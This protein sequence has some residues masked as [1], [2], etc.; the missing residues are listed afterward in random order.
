VSERVLEWRWDE[1]SSGI[2]TV[3]TQGR[4]WFYLMTIEQMLEAQE[5]LW[6]E[7]LST[8]RESVTVVEVTERPK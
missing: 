6:A 4:R 7:E 3:D 8:L 5:R 2:L 1:P